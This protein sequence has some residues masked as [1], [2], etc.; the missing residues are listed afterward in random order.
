[1]SVASKI[2]V[3]IAFVAGFLVGGGVF[4]SLANVDESGTQTAVAPV[5]EPT[6]SSTAK[7]TTTTRPRT[8]TTSEPDLG[9]RSNPF[10]LGETVSFG[11]GGVDYW[12]ITVVAFEPDGNAAVAAENSFNEPPEP[13][14]QF[15]LVTVEATYVGPQEP[16]ILLDLDFG[17]VDDNN[18]AYDFEDTCGVIPNEIDR[19]GDVYRGGTI[20]G[21]LC[22]QVRSDSIDSLL[23]TVG[24]SGSGSP[25]T[26]MALS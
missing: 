25:P 13:G 23:L 17:T 26:F 2:R 16:A 8:S 20:R 15:A 21:N 10:P 19:Y 6:T 3:P 11:R 12:D 14:H 7:R 4:T 1:M 24:S 5:P 22:W 18:V 9:E